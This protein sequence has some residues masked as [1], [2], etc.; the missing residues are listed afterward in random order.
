MKR[1]AWFIAALMV[2]IVAFG[3]AV[4]HLAADRFGAAAQKALESSL[5]RKVTI[6]GVKYNL[7][8]GPGFTISKVK[9]FDDPALSPEPILYAETLTAIPRIWPLFTGKLAFSSIR[10]EDAHINRSEEHTSELQ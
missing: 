1:V 4:P 8:T 2:L 9:I 5:G 7:F 3:F 6:E 10:L